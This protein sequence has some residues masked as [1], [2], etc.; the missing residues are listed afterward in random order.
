M[1][2]TERQLD[3]IHAGVTLALRDVPKEDRREVMND[4]IRVL[5]KFDTSNIPTG[6]VQL[7]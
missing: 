6:K 2:L 3:Y 1:A 4:I 5:F 7:V